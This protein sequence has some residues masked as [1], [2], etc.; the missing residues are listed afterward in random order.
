MMLTV[1]LIFGNNIYSV[2]ASNFKNIEYNNILDN[3]TFETIDEINNK[4]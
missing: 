2:N 4:I 3:L 1:I